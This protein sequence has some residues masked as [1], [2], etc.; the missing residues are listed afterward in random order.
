MSEKEQVIPTEERNAELGERLDEVEEGQAHYGFDDIIRIDGR[1]YIRM[2]VTV[3]G[4]PGFRP[5][6]ERR[7]PKLTSPGYYE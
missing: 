1:C 5:L 7:S 2:E 6:E 3:P 4:Q